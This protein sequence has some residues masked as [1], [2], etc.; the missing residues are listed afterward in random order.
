MTNR[1]A[2]WINGIITDGFGMVE[3]SERFSTV[4]I[5][6]SFFDFCIR[7]GLK[8]EHAIPVIVADFMARLEKGN[9]YYQNDILNRIINSGLKNK[10]EILGVIYG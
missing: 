9:T 6:K 10:E 8:P 7:N 5:P 3:V 1:N 2:E 4:N